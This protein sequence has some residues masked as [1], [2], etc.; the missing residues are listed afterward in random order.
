MH[1]EECLELHFDLKSGRA[2]LSCGDKDY[3]LPDFTPRR[4]RQGSPPSNS[5]GKSSAG[6]TGRANFGRLPNC[7]SGCAKRPVRLDGQA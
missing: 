1:A 2:L 5:L 4:K 6:R 7:R 3:V